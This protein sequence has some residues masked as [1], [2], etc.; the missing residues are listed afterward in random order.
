MIAT[1][2]L[3]V[4]P[5][6]R[7]CPDC[8]LHERRAVLC[9]AHVVEERQ[10][11]K[12]TRRP[13]SYGLEEERLEALAILAH[14]TSAHVNAPSEKVLREIARALEDDSLRVRECAVSIL[15][16][17]QHALLAM[18]TLLDA[19]SA[20]QKELKKLEGA[21]ERLLKKRARRVIG[22]MGEVDVELEENRAL[23][24]TTVAWR[25]TLMRQLVSFPD[26]R[27]VEALREISR[28]ALEELRSALEIQDVLDRWASLELARSRLP[29][30]MD[31]NAPLLALGSL[32]AIA[33]VL[34]NLSVLEN[35]IG[36]LERSLLVQFMTE[37]SRILIEFR[38][39]SLVDARNLTL[40]QI[41]EALSGRD[42]PE[43]LPDP[44]D[45]A[46]LVAWL[47]ASADSRP[48][49]LPGIVSAVW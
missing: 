28:P 40:M 22:R 47:E 11:L 6:Q 45:V 41:R 46:S 3:A 43:A 18:E 31:V 44:L 37:G 48:V 17:P 23:Q 16:P 38:K 2:V 12:A 49:H 36:A 7:E 21:E 13:L 5:T 20:A 9:E 8:R 24:A 14:L 1:L 39:R 15:G 19:L 42:W 33:P 27:V 26:D 35:Q 34:E 4:L 29:P 10:A 30:A 25:R 32:G